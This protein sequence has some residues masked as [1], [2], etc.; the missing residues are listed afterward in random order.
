MNMLA[1][2]LQQHRFAYVAS[3]AVL[4]Q[5]IARL[6]MPNE[7]VPAHRHP[8]R[9]GELRQPVGLLKRIGPFFRM[10]AGE[11]HLVLRGNAVK[12]TG[13]KQFL[14]TDRKRIYGSPDLEIS[15]EQLLKRRLYMFP[16]RF[17]SLPTIYVF[18]RLWR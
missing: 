10:Q 15:R 11:L 6:V 3:P 13:Q 16:H 9:A 17:L 14:R 2:P 1:H 7:R 4:E 5:P 8:V 18:F 12:V